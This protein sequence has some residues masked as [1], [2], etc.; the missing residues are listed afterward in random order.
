MKINREPQVTFLP[1]LFH[2]RISFSGHVSL[3]QAP[4]TPTAQQ[5]CVLLGSFLSSW[6]SA[7][8]KTTDSE[9][10][11]ARLSG[12][13]SHSVRL[14]MPQGRACISKTAP[15]AAQ[16]SSETFWQ[17]FYFYFRNYLY[18]GIA[19]TFQGPRYP[20]GK[21]FFFFKIP[22]DTIFTPTDTREMQPAPYLQC[23]GNPVALPCEDP[24]SVYPG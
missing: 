8:S 5:P 4:S 24:S 19:T 1:F 2:P 10:S 20:T 6:H 18:G 21:V 14:D 11:G 13:V 15:E 17:G 3:Q 9:D 22:L 23:E 16:V 7:L 12:A